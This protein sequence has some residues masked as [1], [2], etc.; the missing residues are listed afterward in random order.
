M[1]SLGASG[2][3]IE[4]QPFIAAYFRDQGSVQFIQPPLLAV[5]LTID[6]QVK[7]DSRVMDC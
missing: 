2:E 5:M 4:W 7:I 1:F 6:P 3:S